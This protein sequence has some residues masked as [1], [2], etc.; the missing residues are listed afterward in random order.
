VRFAVRCEDPRQR[1]VDRG[2]DLLPV[3]DQRVGEIDENRGPDIRKPRGVQQ[4]RTRPLIADELLDG[5]E[6]IAVPSALGEPPL[7]HRQLLRD[8]SQRLHECHLLDGAEAPLPAPSFVADTVL[9][10]GVGDRRRGAD[11]VVRGLVADA[12]G[13]PEVNHPR[14]L[15]SGIRERCRAPRECVA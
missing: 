9:R 3:G 13:V 7:Q 10:A 15:A 1:L 14:S 12:L 5:C 11:L 4:R 2:G 6:R 8:D